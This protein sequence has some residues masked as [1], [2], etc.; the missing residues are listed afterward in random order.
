LKEE[1]KKG[2]T[3]KKKAKKKPKR[4]KTKAVDNKGT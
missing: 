3:N 2:M 1:K 4:L